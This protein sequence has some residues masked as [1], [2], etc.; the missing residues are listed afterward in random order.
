[1]DFVTH[2]RS[3]GGSDDD[4]ESLQRCE[5]RCAR[6]RAAVAGVEMQ[7]ALVNGSLAASIFHES[8]RFIGRFVVG[9]LPA[10]RAPAVEIRE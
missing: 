9:Q 1:M 10:H 7:L 3:A 6:H 8:T 2:A 4:A 5:H